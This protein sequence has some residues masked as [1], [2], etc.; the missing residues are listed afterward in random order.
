MAQWTAQQRESLMALQ[1]TYGARLLIDGTEANGVHLKGFV[2]LQ[3]LQALVR[4][5]SSP[6]NAPGKP[7]IG[8]LHYVRATCPSC[9]YD[10]VTQAY[11][12]NGKLHAHLPN[13]PKCTGDLRSVVWHATLKN[14][15]TS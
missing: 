12:D 7:P 2:S 13:C 11:F 3:D 9:A 6:G 1:M 5:L 14:S 15:P 8:L 4:I 10:L